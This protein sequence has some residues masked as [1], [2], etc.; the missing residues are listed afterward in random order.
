MVWLVNMADTDRPNRNSTNAAPPQPEAQESEL[1][2]DCDFQAVYLDCVL[3]S[4]LCA[5][6]YLPRLPP[7][8]PRTMEASPPPGLA[9]RNTSWE[10]SSPP[11]RPGGRSRRCPLPDLL[12]K[13][14]MRRVSADLI[15]CVVVFPVFIKAAIFMRYMSSANSRRKDLVY[16][17]GVCA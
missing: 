8:C 10:P 1:V 15:N 5:Q 16:V 9:S 2:P 7:V 11:N 12:L 4:V 13:T 14:T 17:L 6:P 3:T